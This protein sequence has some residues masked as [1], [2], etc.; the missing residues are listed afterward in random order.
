MR[1]AFAYIDPEEFVAFFP[2]SLACPTARMHATSTPTPPSTPERFEDF[3]TSQYRGKISWSSATNHSSH[4][5]VAPEPALDLNLYNHGS[6][7]A[8]QP[9]KR[10]EAVLRDS[11]RSRGKT[12]NGKA[13]EIVRHVSYVQR[14]FSLYEIS[15]DYDP[16]APIRENILIYDTWEA[17][18]RGRARSPL[19]MLSGIRG[20]L[21]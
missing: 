9:I 7:S 3:I 12:G 11:T 2:K 1:R 18:K 17:A 5:F 15:F 20:M 21:S 16:T 19:R 4:I 14:L 13:Y 10:K 8:S 6:S